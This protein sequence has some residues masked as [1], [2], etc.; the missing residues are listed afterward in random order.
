MTTIMLLPRPELLVDPVGRQ[1]RLP[2]LLLRAHVP[3]LR[4]EVLH[5]TVTSHQQPLAAIGNQAQMANSR[6]LEHS[7]ILHLRIVSV[8]QIWSMRITVGMQRDNTVHPQRVTHTS[9]HHPTETKMAVKG[10]ISLAISVGPVTLHGMKMHSICTICV[11]APCSPPAQPAHRFVRQKK[12]W[13]AMGSY[14]SVVT[15]L[16]VGDRR[17]A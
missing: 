12:F 16:G 10:M 14:C 2:L 15:I 6:R 1:Q 3:A 7:P 5:P 13:L 11:I 8:L 9:I 17:A 4:L